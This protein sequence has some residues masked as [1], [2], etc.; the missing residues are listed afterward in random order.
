MKKSSWLFYMILIISTLITLSSYNWMGMW[1]GLEMNMM[2]FMPLILN[3]AN[4]SSSEAAMIYFLI[5]SVM[6]MIMFMMIIIEHINY[7]LSKELINLV[8]MMSILT[9]LGAAPFHYWMP[10]IMAKME[11]NKIILL[12]TW[13]KLAPMMMISNMNNSMV[14]NL[15][16]ISSVMVGSLGGINQSSLRKMMGYSS[17]NHLGWMLAIN[18]FV[19]L[20]MIYFIIYSVLTTLMCKYFMISKVYFL[21]QMSSLNMNNMEKVNLFIMMMSMGGLPPFMG[22]LPKWITI[23]NMI[24]NSNYFIMTIM[25]MFSLITLMY[26]MRVM[27]NMFLSFSTTIKW[28]TNKKNNALMLIMMIMN[29]SLPLIMMLDIM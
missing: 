2:S 17:I 5:Q 29:L 9:K 27:T 23:Q 11:W 25:I 12:M 19:S 8:M 22:F 16:I 1:I 14:I 20:W 21:N 18:K 4:K 6:S 26:Y 15:S 10:T 3:K 28:M 13:Q 24:N 7:N